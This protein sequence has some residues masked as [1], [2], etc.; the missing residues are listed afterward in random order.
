MGGGK[1]ALAAEDAGGEGATD[2]EEAGE[3]GTGEGVGLKEMAQDIERAGGGRRGGL[4][5]ALPCSDEVA[6]QGEVIGL[7]TVDAM[8]GEAVRDGDGFEVVGALHAEPELRGHAEVDAQAESHFRGDGTLAADDLSNG[9]RG[10]ANVAGDTVG[11]EAKREHKFLAQDLA[12]MD[13]REES[14]G[15]GFFRFHGSA[16]VNGS[17]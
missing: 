15:S 5:A 9:D 2:I 11:G 7:V 17:R 13:G 8:A 16:R 12:G 4:V 3:V 6:E 1:P 10:A 14:F